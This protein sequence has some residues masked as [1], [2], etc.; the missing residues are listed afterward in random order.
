MA[1]LCDHGEKIVIGERPVVLCLA[2]NQKQAAVVFSYIT[3]IIESTPALASMIAGKTADSLTLENSVV[4]EVRAASFRGLRGVTALAV[5]ADESCFWHNDETSANADSEVITAILPA[6]A[7]TGGPLILISSPYAKKGRTWELYKRHFGPQGDPLILVA[8]GASRD[9]NPSLPQ[10]VV[11]RAMEAD[12]AAASAEYLGQWRSDLE[13][14]ISAELIESAID[15][16]VIVR[17]PVPDVAYVAF[18]DAASGTGGDSFTAAIAHKEGET[19]ILDLLHEVRPPFNAQSAITEICKVLAEYRIS[20]IEGDR[21]SPGFVAEA[22]SRHGV[23]YRYSGRDRSQLYLEAL[24]LITSGRVRLIDSR[25]LAAQFV[26]LERSVSASGRDRVDHPRGDYHDDC[27]N[28][29]AGALVLAAKERPPMTFIPPI[30]GP[31][32]SAT[33]GVYE[34]GILNAGGGFAS[35]PPGGWPANS[36]QAKAANAIHWTPNRGH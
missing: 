12:P 22:F 14:F 25:R 26:S 32:R 7:T 21:Y 18:G 30:A 23:I 5:I 28:A 4:I 15:E 20:T 34:A 1:C 35:A 9:F 33:V 17:P 13:A 16:G 24:P 27:S 10:R 8:Q 11:D 2:Q 31:P 29:A 19:L 3:G 6:L 36:P